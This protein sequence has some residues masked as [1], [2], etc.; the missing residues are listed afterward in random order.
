MCRCSTCCDACLGL[1][2]AAQLDKAQADSGQSR[3][4][5]THQ[6]PQKPSAACPGLP[7]QVEAQACPAA[8]ALILPS[9]EAAAVAAAASHPQA[10]TE[11]PAEAPAQAPAA[12]EPHSHAMTDAAAKAPAEVPAAVPADAPA[13]APAEIA[14]VWVPRMT[15][16]AAGWIPEMT[17]EAAAA[18]A[19]VELV[20]DPWA[21]GRCLRC[22]WT[23]GGRALLHLA[24]RP[25]AAAAAPA[26]AAGRMARAS[27]LGLLGGRWL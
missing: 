14:A 23:T 27:R 11:T 10:M 5:H 16:A 1:K 3:K 20:W 24:L 22:H 25:A 21:A 4:A 15:E 12:A 18:A 17:V 8:P 19:V 2:P 13:E 9:A 6:V 7:W 26:V